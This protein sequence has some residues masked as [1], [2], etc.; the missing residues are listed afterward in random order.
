MGHRSSCVKIARRVR[1]ARGSLG[2][3]RRHSLELD[4]VEVSV[5]ERRITAY[6]PTWVPLSR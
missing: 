2:H 4:E 5:E 6:D 3:R 1:N